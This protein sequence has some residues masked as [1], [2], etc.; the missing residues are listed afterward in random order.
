M[1]EHDYDYELED[2]DQFA[3]DEGPRVAQ[4]Q[5]FKSVK[6]S[7]SY[8]TNQRQ[9]SDTNE[10]S[11]KRWENLYKLSEKMQKL[12][13]LRAKEYEERMNKDDEE[14]T[15]QPQILP[16]SKKVIQ[17]HFGQSRG[18]EEAADFYE[19]KKEWKERQAGRLKELQEK[20]IVRESE[21]CTFKPQ[22]E[23]KPSTAKPKQPLE[24][25]QSSTTK[26]FLERQAKARQLNQEKKE[27]LSLR[28]DYSPMDKK[29]TD[30]K[31]KKPQP[32]I[33]DEFVKE[34]ILYRPFSDAV[35]NL[36]ALLN[37]IEPKSYSCS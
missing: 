36:H 3:E 27:A 24:L 26:K 28:K 20:E 31:G 30:A 23:S 21:K 18:R 12:K 15:F 25:E 19:R 34:S 33:T 29:E 11:N 5:N 9:S 8:Q 10:Q 35:L 32:K 2:D 13:E 16:S 7:A 17:E 4:F 22:I 14:C 1:D 37:Q 6:P